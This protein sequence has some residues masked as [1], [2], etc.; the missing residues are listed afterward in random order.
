MKKRVILVCLLA[1]IFNMQAQKSAAATNSIAV[2]INATGTLTGKVIDKRNNEPL[3]YVTVTVKDA[4]KIITGS[5]TKD[6][7]T[8][9]VSNLPLKEL[10]VEVNFMGYKKFETTISLNNTDKNI[11]LKNIALEDESKQLNEVS[12]IKE[13]S[14]VEQK[15][16]R[17][18]ITVGKDLQNAGATAADIMN[19][20]PSV[21]IDQQNNTVT[22]RGNEN[23]RIFIDGKPSNLTPMQVLQQIP[24]TSIKQVELITNPSAKYN[25]EGMS[26]IINIVLNKNANMGF[27]G[28]FATGTI[29]GITPKFNS[30]LDLNY[31]VNKFNIY[32]NYSYNNGKRINS[33]K[34]LW[35]NYD[36]KKDH[37]LTFDID[38]LK[39]E[40]FSKIGTDFNINDKNTLSFYTIQSFEDPTVVFSNGKSYLDGSEPNQLQIQTATGKQKNQTYNLAY[41]HKFAKEGETLDIE[42]NLNKTNEP[43][44]SIFTDGNNNFIIEN[45]ASKKGE[46]FI[47]NIDYVRPLNET[48]KLELGLESRIEETNNLFDVNQQA[49]A[50]FNFD[51]KI[52]SAYST[53]SKEIGKWSTQLGVRLESYDVKGTFKKVGFDNERFEDYIFTAYP[54]AFVSY[55]PSEKNTFN[56]NYSRRVDRPNM[57]QV[58]KIR[59]WSGLTIEQIG[60]TELKPQFTNSLEINYTRKL[61]LGSLT[62]G[63]FVRFIDNQID[64]VLTSN[65]Y[66]PNKRLMTFRNFDNTTEYGLEFSGD[67][68]FKKWWNVNFG[69]DCYFN[70]NKGIIEKRDGLLYNESI[71]NA[72]FNARMNHT[73]KVN[74]DLRI[75]W[76]TMYNAGQNGLQFSNKDMWKT[77]LGARLNLFKGKGSLAIRYNDIFKTMKA[78]F[79]SQEPAN[80]S[81]EF[82]WESQT[83]NI[84]FNYRFG[85]GKNKALDRKQREQNESRGGGMF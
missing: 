22:L 25:P 77:D 35:D 55:N 53:Y 71:S 59:Q 27:N 5:M 36:A 74:K 42:L 26:G 52:H 85:S 68:N 24:S 64:Q 75:I 82:Q 38:N 18:V 60:N 63:S 65:P 66:D 84:N 47:G 69:T 15:I 16:D 70:T 34:I 58:N 37:N 83:V 39:E 17:K 21:S 32:G 80:I 13:K 81:G 10:T 62:A 2:N 43:E 44:K 33:G 30:S 61:E 23:V 19:N 29:F 48:S 67:L 50:D 11:A 20:I 76:F 49:N 72:L 28:S 79:Y 54:S 45:K 12:I 73:F 3:P 46:N 8:F 56:F 57:E 4:G 41:K 14:T 9:S 40:H 51:R 78:R 1:S 31:K 6:N 7:G